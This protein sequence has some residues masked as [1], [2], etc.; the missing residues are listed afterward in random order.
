MRYFKIQPD[1]GIEW[2]VRER[3]PFPGDEAIQR[4]VSISGP[5]GLYSVEVDHPAENPPLHMFTGGVLIVSHRL[6]ALLQSVGVDN[7]QWWPARLENPGIGQAWDGYFLLNVV[8][9]VAAVAMGASSYTSL[10]AGDPSI[11]PIVDFDEVVLRGD[12]CQDLRM[13]RVP[14]SSW[15]LFIDEIVANAILAQRP[16]ESWGIQLQEVEVR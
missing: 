16:P 4:G 6:L 1:P 13:F 11:A 8:G 7:L 15:L 10:I 14:E 12:R 9:T 3:A 5:S 2:C